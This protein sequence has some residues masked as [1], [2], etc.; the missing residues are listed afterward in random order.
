M[1][2]QEIEK[3][4]ADAFEKREAE[5]L[6]WQPGCITPPQLRDIAYRQ[7]ESSEFD[8]HLKRCARCQKTLQKI[9]TG[10]EISQRPGATDARASTMPSQ[11]LAKVITLLVPSK[12]P[13]LVVS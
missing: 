2:D 7:R 6:H 10:I 9:R 4:I 5:Q 11:A 3:M 1:S 12:Y 8:E 13:V